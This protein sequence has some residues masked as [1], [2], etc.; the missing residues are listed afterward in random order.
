M[1]TLEYML[2]N[3]WATVAYFDDDG[4]LHIGLIE[5]E[6][7]EAAVKEQTDG[8]DEWGQAMATLQDCKFTKPPH[9]A[10]AFKMDHM[11]SIAY[12]AFVGDMDEGP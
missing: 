9:E 10:I 12:E 6:P 3:G 7:I 11:S 2:R 8:E 4:H 1:T 5:R